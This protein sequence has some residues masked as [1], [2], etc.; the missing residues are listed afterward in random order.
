M[1]KFFHVTHPPKRYIKPKP[2]IEQITIAT[3]SSRV[4]D[5]AEPLSKINPNGVRKQIKN[6]AAYCCISR[7]FATYVAKYKFEN[8]VLIE[9]YCETCIIKIT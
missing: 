5:G 9:K 2:T 4:L 8:A 1:H 6:R 3:E 7:N